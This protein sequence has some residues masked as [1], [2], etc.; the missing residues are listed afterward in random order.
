M[1]NRKTEDPWLWERLVSFENLLLAYKKAAK[2]R[3]SRASVAGFEYNLENELPQLQ[4]ELREGS[5]QPG[6][7]VSF[8]VH[9]PK[10]RLISAAPFRDRVA[11][12]ALVNIIE[13]IFERKFIFDTYANRKGKG[14][15]AALDR[16]THYMRRFAYV[17][18]LDVRQFFPSIDHAV[19]LANLQKNIQNEKILGLCRLILASGEG[20]LQ[21]EYEPVYFPGDDLFAINKPR[22]LPI[23]NLTSQ[24][25]ANVY[26]NPLDQFIKRALKCKGYLRY[27][28]DMLLFSNDK[29]ELAQWRGQVIQFLAG[30]RLTV[31]ENSAQPRPTRIGIPFL[32]FQVF[33]D[34]RRLKRR[35]VVH[36]RRRL[37]ALAARY[38]A[39]QIE[40]KAVKARVQAW[41]AHAA[42]GDTW[43]LRQSIFRQIRFVSPEGDSH[44]PAIADFQ[45]DL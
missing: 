37:K 35:K 44:D 19:L 15:H 24:F 1:K 38:R 34:H 16:C 31:H 42:H 29:A 11:H 14:T 32:G 41:V 33:P 17:L 30:L 18:P 39:G 21:E 23:G 7:Y 2:G 28:D 40:Q 9:D 6:S 12:H 26:L 4:A 43:G 25:L 22:G 20:V 3:R 8:Y 5:Y 13:P 45:Q 27:V 10:K 36:A